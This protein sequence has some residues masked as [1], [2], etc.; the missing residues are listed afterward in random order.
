M[1]VRHLCAWLVGLAAASTSL[2]AHAAPTKDECINANESAQASLAAGK[3]R[4]AR[5]KFSLCVARSCPG[6]VRQDCSQRLSEVQKVLPT[7]V[8]AVKGGGGEDLTGVRVR[9]D[10]GLL[11]ARLDGTAIAVDPGR[12]TFN[13]EADGFASLDEPLVIRDGEKDRHEH[14]VLR[15]NAAVAPVPPPPTVPRPVVP[16]PIP[17]PAPTP[18]PSPAPV[19]PP[20]MPTTRILSFA[21]LGVGVA[22]VA[23]G[24]IFGVTALGKKASLDDA[25][26]GKACPP[27]EQSDI[28]GLHSS[29]TVSN[30]GFGVGIVGLAA[31][32]ALFLVSRG[33]RG[34]GQP[35]TAWVT[36][37]FGPGGTGVGGTFE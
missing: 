15:S 4:D 29:A 20:R 30:I 32:T 26:S 13:F 27:S 24:S 36:P 7:V 18:A 10:G 12:H 22:G 33:A 37:W 14:V 8:F 11:T 35:A 3:L 6:P 28:T 16:A 2:T 31:G 34:S 21:A 19:S 17:P 23:V 5:D 1:P 25:C 9:M